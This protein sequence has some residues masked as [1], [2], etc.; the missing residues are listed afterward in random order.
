MRD[1]VLQTGASALRVGGL[2]DH[3]SDMDAMRGVARPYPGG[4]AMVTPEARGSYHQ[5][6]SLNQCSAE[7]SRS[8]Q[9]RWVH[10]MG[11]IG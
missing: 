10:G 9:N 6:P 2:R 7:V 4:D 1:V 8:G 3:Y 5:R 11:V